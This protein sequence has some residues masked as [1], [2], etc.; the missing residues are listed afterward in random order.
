VGCGAVGGWMGGGEWTMEC[1]NK[2]KIKF[3]KGFKLI[4]LYSEKLICLH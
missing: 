3:K 2:F 4:L 1:K